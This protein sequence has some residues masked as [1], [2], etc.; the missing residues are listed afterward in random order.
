MLRCIYAYAAD[1][2][3]WPRRTP[4][5]TAIVSVE[6]EKPYLLVP[7]RYAEIRA[8]PSMKP[9]PRAAQSGIAFHAHAP[10]VTLS[11]RKPACPDIKPEVMGAKVVASADLAVSPPP[12][13]Q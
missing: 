6:T 12:L 7:T 9:W 3:F 4:Q 11:V 8:L 13:H 1:Q 2:G 10:N 5:I